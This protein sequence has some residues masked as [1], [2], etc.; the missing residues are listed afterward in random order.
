MSEKEKQIDSLIIE[1]NK[2]RALTGHFSP[3]EQ[4]M[5][6]CVDYIVDLRR[7]LAEAKTKCEDYRKIIIQLI[8]KYDPLLLYKTEL[9]KV[10]DSG[11]LTSLWN[12]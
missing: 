10:I 12:W 7:Q 5:L 11:D 3:Y 9:D 1:I 2:V 4:N 6:A 8:G